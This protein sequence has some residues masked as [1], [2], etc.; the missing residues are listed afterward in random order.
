MNTCIKVV[1]HYRLHI[2]RFNTKKN[3]LK[4]VMATGKKY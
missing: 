4:I 1:A 3:I 2:T